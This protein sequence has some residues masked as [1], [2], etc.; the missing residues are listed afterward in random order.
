MKILLVNSQ[1]DVYLKVCLWFWDLNV[2]FMAVSTA[3]VIYIA[4][5]LHALWVKVLRDRQIAGLASGRFQVQIQP[6]ATVPTS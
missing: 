1:W 4:D 2:C 6:I 3:N 5:L